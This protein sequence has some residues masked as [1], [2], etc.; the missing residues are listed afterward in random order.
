MSVEIRREPVDTT[1]TI[2][3][4]VRVSGAP[5]IKNGGIGK[6]SGGDFVPE[7][8][9]LR[10][11][12]HRAYGGPDRADGYMAVSVYGRALKAD[13]KPGKRETD[14]YPWRGEELPT[15]LRPLVDD[16]KQY[17]AAYR[18]WSAEQKWIAS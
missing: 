13:G 1:T 17:I 15:W 8:I 11:Y 10:W 9:E 5:V 14:W 7:R 2:K 6:R 3:Q 18:A 16:F 12:T 4:T